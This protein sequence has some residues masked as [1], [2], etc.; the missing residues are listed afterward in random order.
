MSVVHRL[1]Y[2]IRCQQLL[3]RTSPKLLAGFWPNLKGMILIWPSLIILQMVLVCCISRSHRLKI[4]F[5]D[6][7][8]KNLLV[9]DHI[10]LEPWYLVCSI[11]KWI[12]AKFVQII[13]WP[14]P[15]V[16]CFTKAYIR[17]TWK[18]NLLVRKHMAEN[19]DIWYVAS[20]SGLLPSLF[21]LWPWGQKWLYAG[22]DQ[23]GWVDAK[24]QLFQNM[25]IWVAY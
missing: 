13:P 2:V 11:I 15:E 20:S 6:K 5:W 25:V 21:R 8:F 19:L 16:T 10:G 9:W 7:N 12:S 17:K 18:K 22:V 4:D 24:N 14:H 3:Q 1:P 23:R